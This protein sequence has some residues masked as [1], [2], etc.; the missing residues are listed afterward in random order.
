MIHILLSVPNLS[1]PQSRDSF[2]L[3]KSPLLLQD[4]WLGAKHSYYGCKV[5][6]LARDIYNSRASQ[7]YSSWSSWRL[8]LGQEASYRHVSR[9]QYCTCTI[10]YQ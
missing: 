1:L 4:F 3:G 9:A 10:Q 2:N 7:T 6:V 8:R 5:S